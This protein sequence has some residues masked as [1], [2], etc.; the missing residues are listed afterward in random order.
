MLFFLCSTISQKPRG[1][2]DS[3]ELSFTGKQQISNSVLNLLMS[4]PGN[5]KAIIREIK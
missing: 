4:F 5:E 3:Q 1:Q 2:T